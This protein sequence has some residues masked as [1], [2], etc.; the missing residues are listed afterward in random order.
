LIP[1]QANISK[2]HKVYQRRKPIIDSGWVGTDESGKGDYFGPLVVAG[3]YVD[4]RT[5]PQLEDYKVRDSKKISDRVILNLDY[6]IRSQCIYSVVVIG[7]E[8]YNLLY[9][10][11]KNLNRILAWG[12][13]RVIE[14][15]LLKKD[16]NK[17]IS[18]QFGDE[19]LIQQALME[20]GKKITL[21]Q[22]P[23][24]EKDIAVASASIV[25]RAEFLK[26]LGELSKE[27]GILLPKGASAIVEETAKKIVSQLGPEKLGKYAKLH[28][29]NTRNVLCVKK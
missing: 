9:A 22:M 13:A 24:A 4:D 18:D 6:K 21:V 25:A 17:V 29:K 23:R 20:K 7:P 5:T 26:R 2:E 16:C 3:V 8:K 27:C 1:E 14:N 28:F 15:I 12:H 10:K 19:R 11:M